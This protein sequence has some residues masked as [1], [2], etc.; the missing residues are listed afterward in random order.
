VVYVYPSHGDLVL[1]F[2]SQSLKPRSDEYDGSLQHCARLFLELRAETR[3]AVGDCC[4][5][6]VRYSA[7]GHGEEHQSGEQ[8]RA[9]LVKVGPRWQISG[10]LWRT[11][12]T[13]Q[14]GSRRALSLQPRLNTRLPARAHW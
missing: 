11:I 13:A 2:H 7:D 5:I 9:L 10:T 6:A 12:I 14:R 8:S 4:A 3:D 1:G